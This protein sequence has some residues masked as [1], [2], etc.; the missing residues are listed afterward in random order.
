MCYFYQTRWSCGYWRWEYRTG[1]TCGLKLLC[2]DT[3]KKYRRLTKMQGDVARWCREG[4]RKAT[5]ERTNL[6][7][8]EV[9]RQI[10]EMNNQHWT[11]VNLGSY[12][13]M[14]QLFFFFG[15]A[16]PFSPHLPLRIFLHKRMPLVCWT[17]FVRHGVSRV[18][19]TGLPFA[20]LASTISGSRAS[21]ASRGDDDMTKWNGIKIEGKATSKGF[22]S[23]PGFG[24][25][26][27]VEPR[28]GR[29]FADSA[30][31]LVS[32]GWAGEGSCTVLFLHPESISTYLISALVGSQKTASCRML[33]REPAAPCLSLPSFRI[34]SSPSSNGSD[35]ETIEFWEPNDGNAKRGRGI[36]EE[37]LSHF[38]LPARLPIQQVF[39]VLIRFCRRMREAVLRR[40]GLG[41]AQPL[42]APAPF[43]I[44][45]FYSELVK[46][47]FLKAPSEAR[48][49]G[50]GMSPLKDSRDVPEREEQK[51][52][53]GV[54]ETGDRRGTRRMVGCR[55]IWPQHT[56]PPYAVP[57]LGLTP[58]QP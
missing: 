24:G 42:F 40:S 56:T 14:L 52:G 45:C 29:S 7:I 2:Y 47:M 4:N 31:F 23:D 19:A 21:L 34:D 13:G 28:N 58:A 18:G 8:Q 17:C 5:I 44:S 55:P 39:G 3:D 25:N 46:F 54:G 10:Q 27:Q 35:L 1:E 36:D 48:P 37:K 11:R 33:R 41:T 51:E 16:L 30:S 32:F 50:F 9:N 43:V 12:M 53:L 38:F 49:R 15:S 6:E 20:D 57:F 26:F 22:L